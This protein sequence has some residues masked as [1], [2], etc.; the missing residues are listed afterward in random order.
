MAKPDILSGLGPTEA[1]KKLPPITILLDPKEAP[2]ELLKPVR[3]IDGKMVSQMPQGAI[4]V[5]LFAL[6]A[7]EG[8]LEVPFLQ[9]VF[10]RGKAEKPTPIQLAIQPTV[11]YDEFVSGEHTPLMGQYPH[12]VLQDGTRYSIV[13][14][15]PTQL[16][17]REWSEPQERAARSGDGKFGLGAYEDGVFYDIREVYRQRRGLALMVRVDGKHPL[18]QQ[19]A[20]AV[21]GGSFTQ[22]MLIGGFNQS[23][24]EEEMSFVGID[25]RVTQTSGGKSPDLGDEVQRKGTSE[26]LIFA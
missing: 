3:V 12:V 7:S 16:T 9:R 25:S 19:Q 2:A 14:T 20:H 22:E 21:S 8:R 6:P 24:R 26:S 15:A 5:E 17:S 10:S 23:A 18:A 11:E 4:G 1:I 13:V